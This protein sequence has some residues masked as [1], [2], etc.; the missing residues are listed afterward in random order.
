MESGTPDEIL[1][2][3][4]QRSISAI[5]REIRE[6]TAELAACQKRLVQ[7][8]ARREQVAKRYAS[9]RASHLES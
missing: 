7:L 1:M 2:E 6:A 5:D 3:L 9:I 8:S 4:A